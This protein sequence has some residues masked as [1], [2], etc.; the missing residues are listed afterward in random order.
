M[1]VYKDQD[2]KSSVFFLVRL[3]IYSVY[4]VPEANFVTVSYRFSQE[5]KL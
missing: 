2:W 3:E 1:K 5:K 4:V